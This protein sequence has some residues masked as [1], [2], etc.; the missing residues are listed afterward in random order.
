MSYIVPEYR[1]KGLF[2]M[3]GSACN[4]KCNYCGQHEMPR[5]KKTISQK[6]LDFIQSRIDSRPEEDKYCIHFFGGEPLLYWNIIEQVV[7]TFG[8][9]LIYILT[10]NGKLLSEEKVEFFNKWNFHINFSNDGL[11]TECT[12][13]ENLLLD[14]DFC[15][16]F[17]KIKNRTIESLWHSYN[18]DF[19]E[20]ISW[21][22]KRVPNTRIAHD[23]VNVCGGITKELVTYFPEKLIF[24]ENNIPKDFI[25]CYKN[26]LITPTTDY[27]M[28]M[29]NTI[30]NNLETPEKQTYPKCSILGTMLNVDLQGNVFVCH[31]NGIKI[32]TVDDSIE[33]ILKKLSDYWFSRREFILQA[34]DCYNCD[35]VKF[36]RG[37]CPI[38]DIN[39]KELISMACNA[40]RSK[41]NTAINSMYLVEKYLNENPTPLSS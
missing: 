27:I 6:T 29:I 37:G 16:L 7:N 40:R 20:L 9:K 36:C 10:T 21:I 34:K 39:N 11:Y 28:P 17:L 19:Y 24:N 8:S 41:W 4:M 32:G 5:V 31:N 15:E 18:Q 22:E 14:D 30:I 38:E 2:L 35:V 12:G 3:L 23:D 13:R 26:S 25:E 33:F 1:N